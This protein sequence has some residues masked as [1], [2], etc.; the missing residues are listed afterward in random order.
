MFCWCLTSGAPFVVVVDNT[1]CWCLT[2][3]IHLA[4]VD[5][6]VKSLESNF[7]VGRMSVSPFVF[8]GLSVEVKLDKSIIVKRVTPLKSSL[9]DLSD[10]KNL[11]KNSRSAL[12]SLQWVL[13][14]FPEISFGVS[15]SMSK[16][17][18]GIDLVSTAKKINNMIDFVEPH[19][20]RSFC[21]SP[22]NGDSFMI[23]IYTDSSFRN[24]DDAAS[25][26]GCVVSM[27]CGQNS[28][29]ERFILSSSRRLRRVAKSTFAAETLAAS[30]AIDVAFEAQFVL[31]LLGIKNLKLTL[32]T[33]SKSIVDYLTSLNGSPAEVRLKVDLAAIREF[34]VGFSCKLRHVSSSENLADA[35]TK[36]SGNSALSFLLQGAG[37]QGKRKKGE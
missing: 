28:E 16:V 29:Q 37:I 26:G 33:D 3:G 34:L 31:R 20:D 11:S 8:L 25:Q 12:G 4:V 9:I 19:Q 18:K 32:L 17:A 6:V 22:V 24:I 15:S 35:L 27:L 5:S 14:F 36:E 21:F 1:F 10:T 23:N 7:T 13:E 30:D 2:S